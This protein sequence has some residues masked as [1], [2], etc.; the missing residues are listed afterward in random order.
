MSVILKKNTIK[1]KQGDGSYK[2]ANT[3]SEKKTEEIVSEL[4]SAG[5]TIKQEI[6]S[7]GAEVK[8]SIDAY[9]DT[10]PDLFKI[11]EVGV[12]FNINSSVV[13]DNITFNVNPSGYSFLTV[14]GLTCSSGTTVSVTRIDPKA[15]K[16]YFEVS[17]T[18]DSVTSAEVSF[19]ILYVKS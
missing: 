11:S 7:K 19:D 15:G 10:M 16:I 3:I 5:Q 6:E 14:T 17:K 13:S 12:S 9:V 4:E 1:F 18:N 2:Y 8:E